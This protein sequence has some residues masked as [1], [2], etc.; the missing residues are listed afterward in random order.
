LPGINS[1][2]AP[3][4]LQPFARDLARRFNG[5]QRLLALL[6]GPLFISAPVAQR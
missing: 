1:R 3:L 6:G 4:A 5:R 2:E